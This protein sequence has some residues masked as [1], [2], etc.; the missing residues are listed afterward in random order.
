MSNGEPAPAVRRKSGRTPAR[1]R[2]CTGMSDL[3]HPAP[4]PRCPGL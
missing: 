4:L 1:E 2:P 3:L